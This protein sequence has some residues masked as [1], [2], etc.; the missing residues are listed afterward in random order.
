M[1]R[2]I[3]AKTNRHIDLNIFEPSAIWPHSH[4]I[5]QAKSNLA[6][7]QP[8]P[9]L[10]G[11]VQNPNFPILALRLVQ[12]RFFP[13]FCFCVKGKQTH[14]TLDTQTP[15][16]LDTQTPRHINLDT[17]SHRRIDA[18]THRCI[19]T[20]THRNIDTYMPRNIDAKANRHIDS[21]L[22]EPTAIQPHSHII[23]WA[24]SNLATQQSCQQLLGPV[25]NPNFPI[26][27]SKS[28]QSRFF[29]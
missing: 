25:Q 13:Y 5:T 6:A 3:D 27:A 21:Y 10:L 8:Y 26:L 14:R 28:V 19:D 18:Q 12:S 23:T 9:Q 1:P 22:Y 2:H 17:L 7:Q 29:P 15:R 4:I 11:L 24:Q 16:H 20:Q